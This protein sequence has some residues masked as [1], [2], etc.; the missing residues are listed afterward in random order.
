MPSATLTFPP[1]THTHGLAQPQLVGQRLRARLQRTNSPALNN[2][3]NQMCVHCAGNKCKKRLKSVADNLIR[4]CKGNVY[5][6]SA[7]VVKWLKN[8]YSDF[9][10]PGPLDNS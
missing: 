8:E 7:L 6:T 3:N 1:H 10:I 4:F 2:C 5:N 9:S